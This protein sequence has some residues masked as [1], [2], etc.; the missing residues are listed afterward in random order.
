MRRRWI[1]L[2]VAAL[3]GLTPGCGQS[4]RDAAETESSRAPASSAPSVS[5]MSWQDE[6]E[7]VRRSFRVRKVTLRVVD[8][9][10]TKD[11]AS[12]VRAHDSAVFALN[13]GF[14][15]GGGEPIGLALSNGHMLSAP[16]KRP[17]GILLFH[18]DL[19]ASL[20]DAE[21]FALPSEPSGFGIQGLPRLVVDGAVNIR[22]DDGRRAERVALCLDRGAN[23]LDVVFVRGKE[24]LG[25]TLFQLASWLEDSGCVDALNLDGG[26]SA[27]IAWR[28]GDDPQI[29]EIPPRGPIRHAIV[30]HVNNV[31]KLP[32]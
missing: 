14:F 24:G 9:Q 16:A 29:R 7:I 5:S 17:G 23:L 12:A 3:A 21:T 19:G 25:P 31:Q 11:L 8:M 2:V 20:H 15:E 32:P 18:D 1:P 26:P 6:A 13:G 4:P 28:E 27:G 30:I 22:S 10:M